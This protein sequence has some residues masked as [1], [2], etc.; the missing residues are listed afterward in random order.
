M[1]AALSFVVTVAV[2]VASW[3]LVGRP[4]LAGSA[5]RD[6]EGT[7]TFRAKL[8][9]AVRHA[10]KHGAAAYL[11]LAVALTAA[12]P[13]VGDGR[14]GRLVVGAVCTVLTFAAV[15]AL[16]LQRRRANGR[17]VLEPP[18]LVVVALCGWHFAFWPMYFLGL[19]GDFRVNEYLG[20]TPDSTAAAFMACTVGVL[21]AAGGVVLGI[22]RAS[23]TGVRAVPR[24]GRVFYAAPA[25]GAALAVAYFA[26]RG[27][28][29]VG[30]YAG[31]FTEEDGVRRL[32]NLGIVLALGAVGTVAYA[33]R[34]PRVLAAFVVGVLL[35]TFAVASALG[36]RWVVFAAIAVAFAGATVRGVR[37]TPRLVAALATGVL[38][39]G[40][41]GTV[42]K[43]ARAGDLH[44]VSDV[45][46][47]IFDGD[48]PNPVLDLPQELGQT[49]LTV[50]GT[51]ENVRRPPGSP[52]GQDL[53]YGRTLAAPIVTVMPSA[54]RLLGIEAPRPADDFA[55][56]YFPRRNAF[57][58]Y[59]MGF[60]LIAELY[61]NFGILGVLVG[62][63][64][65]G[66]G[67]GR[68]YRW[69][70]ESTGP[71]VTFALWAV[72]AF[73]IFGVR[74]DVY[75]W[76][77]YAVWGAVIFALIGRAGLRRPQLRS[78]QGLRVRSSR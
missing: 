65:G 52:A 32:Y 58:G 15:G 51:I 24:L 7:P 3:R 18:V 60:S 45:P 42:L 40:A 12:V 8:T 30:D 5:R 19:A 27:R 55:F 61:L 62:C 13:I 66:Y 57:E 72:T 4:A 78:W 47:A 1:I 29:L 44:R 68:F 49:F 64:L 20:F 35:P 69:S 39:L 23:R 2:A 28:H 26:V 14:A 74:N 67:L 46:A 16:L 77:R 22:G 9:G 33:E 36:S 70:I 17:L 75:T 6:R 37:F 10:R 34:R 21:A 11:A 50:A 48:A 76:T 38:V 53:Q 59:T 56:I 63:A 71:A 43:V 54:E 25:L 73:A 41:F 31:V